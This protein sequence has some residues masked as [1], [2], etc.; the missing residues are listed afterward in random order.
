M[1]IFKKVFCKKKRRIKKK[2]QECWYNN[3]HEQKKSKWNET[4]DG[5]AFSSSNQLDHSITM[6]I[7]KR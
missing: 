7:A 2:E 5:A 4:V 6:Q 3:Y 1:N